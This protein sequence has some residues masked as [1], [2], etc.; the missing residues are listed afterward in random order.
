MIRTRVFSTTAT[1]VV[2][3]SAALLSLGAP[4]AAQTQAGDPS[5]V[6]ISACAVPLIG[7]MYVIKQPGMPAK[8]FGPETGQFKHTALNWN[9]T[10]P[11]G[12]KGEK[13]DPG[14]QGEKGAAGDKGDAGL[15]GKDGEAGAAGVAGA[16][17]AAGAAGQDGAV[18][19]KGDPCA[20]SEPACRG[21]Q[22]ER[23]Q[24]GDVGPQ[25]PAGTGSASGTSANT[26]NALVQ[27]D[28]NGGFEAGTIAFSKLRQTG[29][30]GVALG[31]GSAAVASSFAL[32]FATTASGTNS[33]A[34][35]VGTTANGQYSTAMGNGTTASGQASTAMG[36]TTLASGKFST[37][38]GQ[39]TRATG[40]FS[41]SMGSGSTAS[42]NFSLATGFVTTASGL[43]STAMG[44]YA[45]TNGKF[46]AFVY[47][48]ASNQDAN[49]PVKATADN[50]FVVRAAGGVVFWTD[51]NASIGV[52]LAANASSWA[53]VSDRNRKELFRPVDAEAVLRN[54]TALWIP[55]WSYKDGDRAR[56]YIGPTAQDFQAAFGLGTDTTI[57]TQDMDGV[58]I[59]A[60]QALG[61]RTERLK[62]ENAAL[63][64]HVAELERRLARLEAAAKP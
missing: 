6:V 37:A 36:L 63:R 3:L 5:P 15:P 31:P 39:A 35:G 43:V 38:I 48:D 46:G 41:T 25:G 8:C 27:R 16:A 2:A 17:G 60:V 50:Q 64:A 59:T 12:A 20:S 21:P 22:G 1:G 49:A 32:G 55:S 51:P 57:A 45:S 29:D 44:A 14:A 18:G 7:T 47:G 53:S 61:K 33:T 30:A 23:G 42:G 4:V 52:T 54:A 28:A 13:G 62:Q 10:G 19:A 9:V 26:P 24:P 40:D 34:M 58:T 56:R 11:A